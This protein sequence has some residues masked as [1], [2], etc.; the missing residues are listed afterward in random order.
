MQRLERA[1]L[2]LT[3]VAVVAGLVLVFLELR[4]N[5]AAI[6]LEYNMSFT[7][8][9]SDLQMA[10]ATNGELADVI[11]RAEGG[12]IETLSAADRVQLQYLFRGLMEPRIA[13]YWLQH[14]DIIPP[15]D[16]CQVM[17]FVQLANADDG[18]R[19]EMERNLSYAKRM[20]AD[21]EGICGKYVP[22]PR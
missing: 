12:Q 1:L 22:S 14:S 16:W 4:Q 10:V 13:Y 3:N 17:R 5:R 11:A 20:V 19:S 2:I 6:E 15:E 18:M 8:I 7:D 21:V 9:M